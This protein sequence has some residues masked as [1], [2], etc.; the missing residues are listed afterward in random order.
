MARPSYPIAYPEPEPDREPLLSGREKRNLAIGGAAVGVPGYLYARGV[1]AGGVPWKQV[2]GAAWG[3]I[4][5]R[6][7]YDIASALRTGTIRTGKDI[8]SIGPRIWRH[9]KGI[10][11]GLA[12]K[13]LSSDA[14]LVQLS[15]KLDAIINFEIR[16]TPEEYDELTGR[17][18]SSFPKAAAL[19]GGGAL[20]GAGIATGSLATR[21]LL[22]RSGK[23]LQKWVKKVGKKI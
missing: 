2:P 21:S 22:M 1:H 4:K 12:G 23:R 8:G 18:K 14:K 11:K 15:A 7:S 3:Q 9:V 6:K 5:G 10:G 17:G 13:S 20:T 16:L 19:I